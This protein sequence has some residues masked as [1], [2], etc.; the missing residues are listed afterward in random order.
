MVIKHEL[1]K[2][3]KLVDAF[4]GK[5]VEKAKILL[6]DKNRFMDKGNGFY[7]ATNLSQGLYDATVEANG[8]VSKQVDILVAEVDIVQLVMLV[9]RGKIDMIQVPLQLVGG[10]DVLHKL[11]IFYT[12]DA[13]DL[14]RVITAN[15]QPDDREIKLQNNVFISLEG[16]K[17]GLPNGEILQLGELSYESGKYRF[18]G[19]V[20]TQLAMGAACNLLLE[21]QSYVNGLA[22]LEIPSYMVQNVEFELKIFANGKCNKY[23]LQKCDYMNLVNG[24]NADFGDKVL[25]LEMGSDE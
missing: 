12:V 16:R 10:D 24:D 21:A 11:D 17:M 2:L 6:F 1:T 9:P 23:T 25:K 13:P 8:Y 19:E 14:K 7:V 4:S 3:V 20:N 18:H 15:L 5:S 22:I